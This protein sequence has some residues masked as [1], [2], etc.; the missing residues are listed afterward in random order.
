VSVDTVHEELTMSDLETRIHDVLAHHRLAA[1]ATCTE[2]GRPWV[3][4]VI[5]RVD[6]SLTLTLATHLDSRKVAHLRRNPEVHLTCGVLAV[7]TAQTYVQV[8]GR[9]VVVT[10][11]A[12]KQAWWR[13]HLRRWF[14]GPDD[15]KYCL[16]EIRPYRIELMSPAA[17]GPQVWTPA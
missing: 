1:L 9:A 13:D 15:P 16:V 3:R 17:E 11:A 10:E 8:E 14:T 2:D 5:P 12:A 4:Y 6:E 7:E